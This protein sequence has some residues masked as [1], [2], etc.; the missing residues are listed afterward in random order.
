MPS[1]IAVSVGFNVA[2]ASK[3]IESFGLLLSNPKIFIEGEV[4]FGRGW[5]IK[6]NPTGTAFPC[7]SV[8]KEENISAAFLTTSP[9]DFIVIALDI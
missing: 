2:L 8:V 7:N 5:K 3:R 1:N 4:P 9:L 6:C